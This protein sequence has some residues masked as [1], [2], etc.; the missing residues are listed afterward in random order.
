[1]LSF[2]YPGEIYFGLGVLGVCFHRHQPD[3][4]VAHRDTLLDAFIFHLANETAMRNIFGFVRLRIRYKVINDN[5]NNG[6]NLF[7]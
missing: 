7:V 5:L 2:V 3:A 4:A 1:M 6:N